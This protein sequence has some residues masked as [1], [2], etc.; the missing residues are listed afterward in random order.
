M[1]DTPLGQK[2]RRLI[3]ANG[4]MSVAEYMAHC[5]GDPAHGYYT[6]RD[7]FGAGGDFIT[8]PEVSQMFGEIVGAWL[9]EAW[10]LAGSPDPVALVEL[11]PGRGTLM[12]DI[13]RVA[14]RVPGIPA[15]RVG[16]S[17]RDEPGAAEAAGGCARRV[18]HRCAMARI[19]RRRAGRSAS[20]RRE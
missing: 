12:A 17:R 15:S 10:R 3:A 20:P 11:G 16:A 8:A 13:L 2:L 6:T 4:P 9:I 14:A 1:N 19:V 18:R 5:L 7:P